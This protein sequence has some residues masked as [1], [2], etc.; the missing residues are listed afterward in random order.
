MKIL[1]TII[2]PCK[3]YCGFLTCLA[4]TL[5]IL[6]LFTA[7][8][9]DK[10]SEDILDTI[11]LSSGESVWT[12]PI[13]LS[14]GDAYQL[15][16]SSN[17]EIY[18]DGLRRDG[19]TYY[20]F[21]GNF[22]TTAGPYILFY[23][24]VWNLYNKAPATNIPPLHALSK[25]FPSADYQVKLTNVTN[26]K[27]TID[28]YLA[29]KAD[30]DFGSGSF[31]INLFVYTA[32]ESNEVIPNEGEAQNIKN[33]MNQIFGRV[34]VSVGNVNVEFRD[35]G[36]AISQVLTDDGMLKFLEDASIDTEG[37]NDRGINCFLFPRL[38]GNT[39]GVDGAIPG[40][41]GIH[42]VASAGL[43]AQAASLGFSAGGLTAHQTDQMILAKILAHEIG[44]Y[45]GLFHTTEYNGDSIGAVTD[46]PVCGKENDGNGDGY[47]VGSECRG[48]GADYLMFWT[49]DS[50][51]VRSGDFQ[52]NMSAQEG[53]VSNTHPSVN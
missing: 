21:N 15:L 30:T 52:L 8:S 45:F 6:I 53:Q 50:G 2:R 5:F 16:F 39:L 33:Y 4:A 12:D 48:K 17:R 20:E 32:G 23:A 27:A 47:V 37:R 40:P 1:Q 38:S 28:I 13:N 26:T 46:T 3:D 9:G 10:K 24:G 18:I 49:F 25:D 29:K 31:D 7:C 34:G 35:D 36:R 22:A 42:G 19:M 14:G 51:L 41:G 44:H 11:K 43:I